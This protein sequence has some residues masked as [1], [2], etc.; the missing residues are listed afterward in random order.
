MERRRQLHANA[1]SA[2][3][4]LNIAACEATLITKDEDMFIA[5][6]SNGSVLNLFEVAT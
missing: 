5:D 3:T 1:I 2:L 6:Q 4:P